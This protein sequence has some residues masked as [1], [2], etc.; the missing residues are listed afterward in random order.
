M[1]FL[2]QAHQFQ[3]APPQFLDQGLHASALCADWRYPWGTSAAPLVGRRAKLL[4][5]VARLKQRDLFPYD[6]QTALD[7][8]FIGQCL[9]WSPTPPTPLATGKITV[10]TLLINGD[11]DLSTPLEWAR[12]E[13]KLAPRGKLVV[14]PGAGHSVQSRATSDVGRQAVAAFLLG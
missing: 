2:Q 12:Q 14:V 11:H 4:R 6:R 9:P 5:A 8:G 13:L 7:N 10:P 1:S 3:A